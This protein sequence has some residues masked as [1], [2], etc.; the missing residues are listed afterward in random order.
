MVEKEKALA[1][2]AEDLEKNLYLL[3]CT[4]VED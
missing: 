2:L 4:A 3:G 1:Q